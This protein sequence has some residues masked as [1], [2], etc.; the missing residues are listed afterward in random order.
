MPPCR[1]PIVDD[2]NAPT[3]AFS[4]SGKPNLTDSPAPLDYV[5]ARRVIRKHELEFAVF[6]IGEKFQD[7][8]GKYRRFD[9]FHSVTVRHWRMKSIF[10]LMALRRFSFKGFLHVYPERVRDTGNR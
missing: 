7:E 1:H 6:V 4:F 10:L 9:K 2:A 5:A 8:T 3:F